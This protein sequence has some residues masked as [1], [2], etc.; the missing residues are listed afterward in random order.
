MLIVD[1]LQQVEE[2]MFNVVSHVGNIR[3]KLG[4]D[5]NDYVQHQTQPQKAKQ[6]VSSVGEQF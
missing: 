4:A 2:F 5:Q 3:A 6:K 1:V